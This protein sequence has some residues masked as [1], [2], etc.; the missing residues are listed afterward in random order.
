M[1]TEPS[2]K[3]Q[4]FLSFIINEE[5][6]AINVF[7]VI[8]ILEMS[9]ITKLPKAPDF[10]K[11]VINLRGTILQVVDMR[12]RF[13]FPETETTEDT[14]IIV[15]SINLNDEPV[16]IG[17]IVDFVKEV[18]ELKTDEIIPSPSFGSKYNPDFI[19]GM[20][21]TD[22]NLVMILD[23]EK[24]FSVEEI[25]GFKEYLSETITNEKTKKTIK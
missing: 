22:E 11:G 18:L 24:V 12:I 23:I 2:D 15:L 10:M 1:K 6:F 13:G 7:K 25:T 9:P 19:E 4:T 21:R 5:V 20:W 8:S 3:I 17:I 14:S 16:L